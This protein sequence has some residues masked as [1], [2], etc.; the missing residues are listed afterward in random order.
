MYMSHLYH[1]LAN[2]RVY[3]SNLRELEVILECDII[4]YT[5]DIHCA[6][7]MYIMLCCVYILL[8]ACHTFGTY[9]TYMHGIRNGKSESS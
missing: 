3:I 2:K 9:M 4:W 7:H 5:S 8:L 6:Y 1:S